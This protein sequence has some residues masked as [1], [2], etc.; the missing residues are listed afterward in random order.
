MRLASLN[1]LSTSRVL[2]TATQGKAG[3][4]FGPF[5]KDGCLTRGLCLQKQSKERNLWLGH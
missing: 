2:K 1:N 5:G 4:E 3:H